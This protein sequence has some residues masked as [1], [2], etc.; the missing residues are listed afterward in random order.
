MDKVY[1]FLE[2]NKDKIRYGIFGVLGL[3]I[4]AF[5]LTPI[6]KYFMKPA[7]MEIHILPKTAMVKI[8]GQEYR[9]GIYEFQPGNYTGEISAN[10]YE[11]KMVDFTVKAHE[12][13][14]IS[15][16][17]LCMDGTFN[18]YKGDAETIM[19]MKEQNVDQAEYEFAREYL[20]NQEKYESDP[21]NIY[22]P[23]ESYNQGFSARVISG[24]YQEGEKMRI[25][26]ELSTCVEERTKGLKENFLAWMGY[27]EMKAE[28]YD[29]VYFWCDGE[30]KL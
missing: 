18:C 14:K 3:I 29:I 1:E 22:L 2:K 27:H 30:K 17:L 21:A 13:V 10:G 28:D 12:T 20:D 26:V 19:A 24:E 5:I 25:R 16:Y 15:N 7:M 4:V 6:V 23:Y 11:T 9:N 8:N